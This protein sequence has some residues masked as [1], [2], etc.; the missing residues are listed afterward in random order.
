M[1]TTK[2]PRYQ[3]RCMIATQILQSCIE[4][5]HDGCP[6]DQTLNVIFRQ[7]KQYGS[8]DRRFYSSVV[9]AWFRWH[10][11]LEA[12]EINGYEPQCAY[13]LILEGM[14]DAPELAVWLPDAPA[15]ATSNTLTP[16]ER[17]ALVS[18]LTHKPLDPAKAFPEWLAE[19]TVWREDAPEEQRFMAYQL[20]PPTWLRVLKP[21][22]ITTLTNAIPDLT[23]S[24]FSPKAASFYSRQNITQLEQKMKFKLEVQDISSQLVGL[25]CNPKPREKWWDVCAASGG[26]TVQL[27]DLAGVNLT[28]HATDVRASILKNL[29]NR[30]RRI[31]QA[32]DLKISRLKH[33]A[34]PLQWEFYD[35]VLVDAP[36]S[37]I[38]TW[39]RNPD[40][41]DRI[42][43]GDID[44]NAQLQKK[45]LTEAAASVKPGGRLIYSVCTLTRAETTEVIDTFLKQHPMFTP[46]RPEMFSDLTTDKKGYFIFPDQFGGCNGMYLC[47]LRKTISQSRDTHEDTPTCG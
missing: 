35:G 39:P 21:N 23:R 30:T 8:K 44:T 33:E 36:C 29:Q 16:A 15:F 13:S 7:N 22:H 19:R 6:T 2:T 26:K 20:R 28:L 47:I 12:A 24:A 27:A 9:F 45:L 32:H 1:N 46:V 40:A 5:V 41:R 42:K 10:R 18:E 34:L 31:K 43:L 17:L 11:M 38:G 4:A 37:G 14:G 25:A 3:N